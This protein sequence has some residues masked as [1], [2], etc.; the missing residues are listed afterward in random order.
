MADSES[1]VEET[2]NS[3]LTAAQLRSICRA[4]GFSPPAGDKETLA[5]FVAPRL[6]ESTGAAEAMATLKDPWLHVLHGIA[7]AEKPPDLGALLPFA[8]PAQSTYGVDF[9]ALYRK[10]AEGLLSRG[11]V[12][13]QDYPT[14]RLRGGSRFERLVFHLPEVHHSALPPYPVD[15][16]PLGDDPW[17]RD[18]AAFCREVLRAAVRGEDATPD[19]FL[20]RVASAT[21]LG[22]GPIRLRQ[23]AVTDLASFLVRVRKEWAAGRSGK[24]ASALRATVHIVSHL[25]P[26]RGVTVKQVRAALSRIDLVLSAK[27]IGEQLESGCAAGL[28][29]RGG[30]TNDPCYRVP[31]ASRPARGDGPLVFRE[32]DDGVRVDLRKTGLDSFLGLAAVC[33]TKHS[34]AGL[35]LAPHPVLLGRLASDIAS[36]PAL[37]EVRAACPA[38]EKAAAN[39]EK[40][41]GKLVLHEGLLVLRVEDP[42]MRAL[43]TRVLGDGVRHVAGSYM[44][45][46]RGLAA[47]VEKLAKKEGFTPRRVT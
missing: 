35:A 26:G 29:V 16:V 36:I 1:L 6:L 23:A 42:G 32:I 12:L 41:H 37:A 25:P 5:R 27:A 7:M 46:P 30:D 11:V 34:G 18:P 24:T 22:E 2:C 3:H 4:R 17:S 9:R 33:R 19:G 38:F 13:V 45:A 14:W 47:K 40:R 20:G 10:L 8:R 28:V 43:L 15:T 39:A 31:D 44:V 21:V